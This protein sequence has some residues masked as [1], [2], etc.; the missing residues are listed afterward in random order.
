M[1]SP[2]PR[3]H[4][5][6]HVAF[7]VRVPA[8]TVVRRKSATHLLARLVIGPPL[9]L[10]GVSAWAVAR[11]RQTLGGMEMPLRA[12]DGFGFAATGHPLGFYL[13][14]VFMTC[15]ARLLLPR[16]SRKR[17]DHDDRWMIA[18]IIGLALALLVY[19]G[20]GCD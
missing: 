14:A 2:R 6:T 10:L 8:A 20:A 13:V 11:A 4:E 7:K 12:L 19:V 3:R 9:L 1:A 5:D 17:S 15:F 18:G 16:L